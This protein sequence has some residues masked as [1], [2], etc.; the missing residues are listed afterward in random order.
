MPPSRAA[1]A[2]VRTILRPVAVA[3]LLP[4]CWLTAA[5]PA[6]SSV[7]AQA[8]ADEEK[9]ALG[10][11]HFVKR[12]EVGALSV[13]R[14]EE[15]L[16]QMLDAAGYV[17]MIPAKATETGKA[18]GGGSGSG[19]QRDR[20]ASPAVKALEKADKLMAAARDMLAES[21]ENSADATKLITAAA[22]RYEQNFVEL[23]DFSKLS[24]AYVALASLAHD[25]GD[26]KTAGE[27]LTKALVIQPSL[28]VDARKHKDLKV[29]VEK[30]RLAL[31]AKPRTDV[32][33]ECREENAEVYVDGVKIGT[34]PATAKDLLTGTHYL[35]VRKSNAAPWGQAVAVKGK[36][37]SVRAVLQIE[38]APQDEIAVGVSADDI[39]DMANKGNFG[40]KIF[41][42]SGSMFARQVGATHL[43]FGLVSKRPSSLELHL[44]LY[45]GKTKK[46]CSIEKI[47]YA[48]NLSNLQMQTLD[49]ESKV[50]A[51]LQSCSSDIA[52]TPAC[53]A[54]APEPE[55]DAPDIVAPPPDENPR[56]APKVEPRVEPEVEPKVEPNGEP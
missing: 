46:T 23:V 7:G 22:D 15:Y 2:R 44:F 26:Q 1:L 42:N 16:R 43:L 29:F 56:V 18:V 24:D 17:K 25:A 13:Q 21:S 11:I 20:P 4:L 32:Q 8:W 10:I 33:V 37:L 34:A 47:E 31:E 51:A 28:V 45:N 27:W 19:A 55:P 35:Q 6:G 5:L 30:T 41:K 54:G 9:N 49:A 50:R 53:F 39:K 36:P 38:V 48:A 14:I 12:G 3:L 52:V 40:E